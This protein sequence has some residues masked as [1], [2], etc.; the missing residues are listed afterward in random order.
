M[1]DLDSPVFEISQRLGQRSGVVMNFAF[2][3][4]TVVLFTTFVVF[5][6]HS[7]GGLRLC[8]AILDVLCA[9]N[10]IVVFLVAALVQ[11]YRGGELS[12][13]VG[14]FL[15]RVNKNDPTRAVTLSP[16]LVIPATAGSLAPALPLCTAQS[17][18]WIIIPSR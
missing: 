4:P 5:I 8:A 14:L 2:R 18:C 16:I 3:A 1:N 12:G 6:G 13:V 15:N 7:E 10:V 11:R 9:A 17:S